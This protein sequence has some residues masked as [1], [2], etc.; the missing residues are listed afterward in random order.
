MGKR[1]IWNV[2]LTI[3]LVLLTFFG[4]GPVLYADG[5]MLERLV[6]L[7]VVIVLYVFLIMAFYFVNTKIK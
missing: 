1:I 5:T 3:L 4:L 6:T 7:L 2:I